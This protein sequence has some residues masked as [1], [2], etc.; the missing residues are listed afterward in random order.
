M[1][2]FLNYKIKFT[3]ISELVE[4]AINNISMFKVNTVDDI[5]N[6]DIKTREYIRQYS[7]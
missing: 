4:Y 5:I 7:L 6:M 2:L 3:E 1:K